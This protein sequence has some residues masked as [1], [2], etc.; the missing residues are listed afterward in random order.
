VAKARGLGTMSRERWATLVDQLVEAGVVPGGAVDP[1][2]TFEAGF[3]PG[4][5]PAAGPVKAR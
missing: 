3:L 5:G 1:D 4:H 2:Q